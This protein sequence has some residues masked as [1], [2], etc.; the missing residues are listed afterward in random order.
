V[1][2]TEYLLE[3]EKL[4]TEKK[5]KYIKRK[6]KGDVRRWSCA[7]ALFWAM[8]YEVVIYCQS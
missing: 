3:Y 1:V 7:F 4:L 2:D 8:L 6:S 5:A